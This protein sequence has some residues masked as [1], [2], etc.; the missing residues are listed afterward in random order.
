MRQ[1][2]KRATSRRQALSRSSMGM[3]APLTNL[4]KAANAASSC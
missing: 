4:A 2:R 1:L 3:R